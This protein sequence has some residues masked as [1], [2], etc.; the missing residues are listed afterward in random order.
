VEAIDVKVNIA[1]VRRNASH[2]QLRVA[3]PDVANVLALRIADPNPRIV[4]VSVQIERI[5]I[6]HGRARKKSKLQLGR[7]VDVLKQQTKA[8]LG[9]IIWIATGAALDANPAI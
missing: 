4:E 9:R 1:R 5:K 6:A 7:P 3:A 2:I 8:M